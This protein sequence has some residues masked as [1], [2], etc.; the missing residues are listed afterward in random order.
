MYSVLTIPR[1]ASSPFDPATPIQHDNNDGADGAD[2]R[3]VV[4]WLVVILVGFVPLL[5]LLFV[6]CGF[7]VD[8]MAVLVVT[9]VALTGWTW[10]ALAVVVPPQK[11]SNRLLTLQ[12]NFG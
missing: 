11:S 6:L 9:V 8:G 7:R 3:V 2:D 1:R 10:V 5:L 12:R 4:P